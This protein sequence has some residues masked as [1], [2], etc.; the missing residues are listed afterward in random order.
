MNI[1][2]IVTAG[3]SFTY[4][5]GLPNKKKLGWPAL[6]AEF[7]NCNLVNLGTPGVGNDYISRRVYEYFYKNL[8]F[9]DSKPLFIIAW[10]QNWRRE[11]WLNKLHNKTYNDFHIMP[12]PESLPTDSYEKAFLENFNEEEFYRKELYYKLTLIH[13]LDAYDIPYIMSDYSRNPVSDSYNKTYP[14]LVNTINNKNKILDF[15]PI[16]GKYTTLPCGHDDIDANREIST[17]AIKSIKDLYPNITFQNDIS[18]LLLRNF[19]HTS[20]YHSSFPD[21]I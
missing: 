20:R 9:K 4:C 19:F 18:Y 10:T 3:C 1:S 15:Y 8:E 2:H 13:L 6:I 21:W 12:L 14:E 11:Y 5:Q 16:S 7:F 17:I